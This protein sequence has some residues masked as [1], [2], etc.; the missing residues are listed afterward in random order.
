MSRELSLKTEALIAKGIDIGALPCI[1]HPSEPNYIVAHNSWCSL[2]NGGIECTCRPH[3]FCVNAKDG[4]THVLI[5]KR[6]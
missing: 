2:R 5:D 3:V 1:L 6:K 4:H